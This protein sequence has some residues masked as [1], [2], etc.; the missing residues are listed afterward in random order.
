MT[1][2]TSLSGLA[3]ELL[4]STVFPQSPQVAPSL[5]RKGLW[6]AQVPLNSPFFRKISLTDIKTKKMA[7]KPR[8]MKKVVIAD[9]YPQI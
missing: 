2:S 5:F 4:V 6:E 9:K 3:Q 8:V 7:I 1:L